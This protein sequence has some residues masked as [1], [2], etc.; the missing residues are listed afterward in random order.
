M[1]KAEPLT[2]E[3]LTSAKLKNAYDSFFSYR[4]N[5]VA[6]YRHR[7][8]SWDLCYK[9][10]KD[11]D[12]NSKDSDKNSI[13]IAGLHLGF[14]LASWG[15]FR[16]SSELLNA[17]MGKFKKLAESILIEWKEV[18]DF[19]GRYRLIENFFN[20]EKISS[21]QTLVTKTMLGVYS[22]TPAIDRFFTKTA[23]EYCWGK[24]EK[25]NLSDKLKKIFDTNI[26][27]DRCTIGCFIEEKVTPELSREK[28][29]DGIFFQ[30]GKNAYF[31]EKV[32]K[33]FSS[34]SEREDIEGG[35][36]SDESEIKSIIESCRKGN[37]LEYENADLYLKKLLEFF[38][39]NGGL[40]QNIDDET[41]QDNVLSSVI[42]NL[43][44]K[45]NKCRFF[46]KVKKADS[47]RK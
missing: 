29:L 34:I 41:D 35:L 6:D 20:K 22:N 26:D 18:K 28:I 7:Y 8:S 45:G 36:D 17:G 27:N 37:K 39:K 47:G 10:F 16:G 38:K 46:V 42:K 19:E 44:K 14:Y 1:K 5:N 33:L 9:Y 24:K 12:T 23:K 11:F 4:T 43:Q 21:T 40:T 15:M 31:A 32:R 30:I 3:T 25:N 2:I 13:E